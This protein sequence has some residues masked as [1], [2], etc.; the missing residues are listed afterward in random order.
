VSLL[1]GATVAGVVCV[2]EKSAVAGPNTPTRV[3]ALHA[4]TLGMRIFV[5]AACLALLVATSCSKPRY[6]VVPKGRLHSLM[7]QMQGGVDKLNAAMKG[8]PEQRKVIAVLSRIESIAKQLTNTRIKS[9]HT[10]LRG[11]A[12]AFHTAVL[13]ALKAAAANPPNY[14]AAGQISGACIHCHDPDGGLRTD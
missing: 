10:L 13:T 8:T 9:Q 6:N 5:A 7:W 4:I 3:G 11:N 12:G 14:Y 1:R 2:N